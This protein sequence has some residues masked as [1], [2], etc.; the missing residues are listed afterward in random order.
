MITPETFHFNLEKLCDGFWNRVQ[1]EEILNQRK[2]KAVSVSIKREER[3]LSVPLEI[4]NC[5]SS[6]DILKQIILKLQDATE[7]NFE[8]WSNIL[9]IKFKSKL[10]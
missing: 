4:H 9:C 5:C 7:P 8:P 10:F 6:E 3:S 1:E 2:P